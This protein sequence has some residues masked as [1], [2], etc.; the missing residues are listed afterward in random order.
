M[1]NFVT[2]SFILDIWC[3]LL[4]KTPIIFTSNKWL[5]Y[6]TLIYDRADMLPSDKSVFNIIVDYFIYKMFITRLTFF[7]LRFLHVKYTR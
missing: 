3:I 7:N 1:K 2:K 4:V 6:Y 5:V